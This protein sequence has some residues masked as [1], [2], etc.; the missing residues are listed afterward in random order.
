M[1]LPRDISR[2]MHACQCCDYVIQT[3]SYCSIHVECFYILGVTICIVLAFSSF[4]GDDDEAE[5]EIEIEMTVAVACHNCANSAESLS[6]PLHTN[7][8]R[9]NL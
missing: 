8:S 9:F 6:W 5:A 1:E 7:I 4:T 2:T 3:I